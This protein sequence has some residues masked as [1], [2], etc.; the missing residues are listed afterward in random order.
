MFWRL[1]IT[2]FLLPLS[3]GCVMASNL[4]I[5]RTAEGDAFDIENLAVLDNLLF[6]LPLIKASQ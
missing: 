6:F 4:L 5:N 1:R 3:I 2:G